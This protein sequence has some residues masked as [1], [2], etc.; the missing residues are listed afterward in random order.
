MSS[1]EEFINNLSPE[2]M[3]LL[4]AALDK[5]S[6]KPV[7][8]TPVRELPT[9]NKTNQEETVSS[10]SPRRRVNEDFTVV[11]NEDSLDKRKIPV[12][13]KKN[14]WMDTGEDRDPDFDPVKFERMGK[15]ARNRERVKKQ[16]VECHVCGRDFQINPNLVYGEFIRCNRCTGK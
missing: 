2:Q 11:R 9:G 13:A 12:R 6:D 8:K 10:K 15:T 1:F 3:Q 16:T 7:A 14:Q 5:A 4:Q